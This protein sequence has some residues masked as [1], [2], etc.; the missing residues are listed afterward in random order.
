[1]SNGFSFTIHGLKGKEIKFKYRQLTPKYQMVLDPAL[2]AVEPR[3]QLPR[4]KRRFLISWWTI[5][6]YKWGN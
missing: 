1:M 2:V 6:V 3:L 4:L 5:V